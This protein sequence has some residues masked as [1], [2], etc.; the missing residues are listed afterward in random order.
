MIKNI[1][2]E[3]VGYNGMDKFMEHF[4][5]DSSFEYKENYRYR[6][7]CYMDSN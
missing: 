5:L 7:N 3:L 1:I 4:E 2:I 6:I